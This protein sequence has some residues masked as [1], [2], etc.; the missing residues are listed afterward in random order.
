[1]FSSEIVPSFSIVKYPIGA[2]L[3]L[4]ANLFAAASE[5]SLAKLTAHFANPVQ[6]DLSRVPV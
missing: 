2:K 1:M 3:Y 4:A 6:F 5:R